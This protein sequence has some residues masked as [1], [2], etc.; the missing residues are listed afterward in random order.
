MQIW[1]KSYG[2]KEPISDLNQGP[3]HQIGSIPH[4]SWMTKDLRLD[5]QE[6][7]VKPNNTSLKNENNVVIK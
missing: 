4:T 7:M 5:A 3:H 1:H 2:H 6:T